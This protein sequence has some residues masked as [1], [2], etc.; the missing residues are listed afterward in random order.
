MKLQTTDYENRTLAILKIWRDKKYKEIDEE[1]DR[2]IQEFNTKISK[3]GDQMTEIIV[4]IEGFINEG[5][6][7]YDQLKQLKKEIDIMENQVNYL[8]S[9]KQIESAAQSAAAKFDMVL[10]PERGFYIT[11]ENI[12]EYLTITMP[13]F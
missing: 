13:K 9:N 11:S 6:V 1:Y 5:E 2:R 12:H 8:I 4:K 10:A 3:Q 7:S